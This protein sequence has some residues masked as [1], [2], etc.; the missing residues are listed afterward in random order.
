MFRQP[1]EPA[2]LV[3]ESRSRRGIAVWQ[4]EA[5]DDHAVDRRF[6]V[7]A[8]R[9]VGIAGQATAGFHRLGTPRQDRDAVPPFLPMPDRAV[10]GGADRRLRKLLV[11]RLQLLKTGDVQRDLFQPRQQT[12]QAPVDAVYVVGRDQHRRLV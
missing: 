12:G 9:V 5:S 1:V 8:V 11:G 7:A 2:Q 10:A 6:D 4:I 3:I